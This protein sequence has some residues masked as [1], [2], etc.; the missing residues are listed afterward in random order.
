MSASM[1]AEC[2]LCSAM[3]TS[4]EVYIELLSIYRWVGL[5]RPGA[6]V[7]SFVGRLV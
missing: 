3:M 7:I 5:C 1:P 2:M 6:V 4:M